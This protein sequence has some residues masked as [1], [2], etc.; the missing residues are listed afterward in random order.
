MC[1]WN[2]PQLH[3]EEICC[4]LHSFPTWC[5]QTQLTLK[6]QVMCQANFFF[7]GGR[8]EGGGAVKGGG[9]VRNS[10]TDIKFELQNNEA[11]EEK[12]RERL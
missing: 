1:L 4:D 10:D 3:P 8:G 7:S 6:L 5:Q 2:R 11:Q 9:G 12:L